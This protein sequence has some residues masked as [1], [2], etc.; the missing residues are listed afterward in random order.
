MRPF[1]FL[2]RNPL[3]VL[4]VLVVTF[5]TWVCWDAFAPSNTP[6]G[7]ITHDRPQNPRVL[8]TLTTLELDVPLQAKLTPEDTAHALPK[9]KHGMPR[10]EVEGLV[11]A[12]V[13]ANISPATVADGRVVYQ[14]WYEADF[15]PPVTVRPIVRARVKATPAPATPPALV[16]LE[17]DATKPGHPLVGVYYP[18]PLF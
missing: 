4:A 10:T 2:C 14:T 17:F 6:D 8:P 7:Q 9:L 18:D 15:A 11:G 1:R 3:L 12:P 13:P 5:A 16:A